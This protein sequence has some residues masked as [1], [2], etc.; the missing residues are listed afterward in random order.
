[1]KSVIILSILAAVVAFSPSGRM[2]VRKTSS[3]QMGDF[4]KEIGAQAP[5]GFW[6]PLG[7]LM[8][9]EQE[10][11]DYLRDAELKHGRPAP[12]PS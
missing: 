8:N 7:L 6:D 1:M 3:L 4:S 10:R 2:M 11:F 5:L 12:K 9:A